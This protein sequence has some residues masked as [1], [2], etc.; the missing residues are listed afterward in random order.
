MKCKYCK[1]K[2][3]YFHFK[4]LLVLFVIETNITIKFYL[5]WIFIINENKHIT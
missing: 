5:L 3:L 2:Y 4:I 1:Y